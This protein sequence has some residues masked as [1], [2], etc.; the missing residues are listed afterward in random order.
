M[1]MAAPTPGNADDL[2][3]FVETDEFGDDWQS[4]GL[5]VE[6]DLLELQNAIM[7]AT[8]RAPVI[9]VTGGLRKM[10]FAPARWKTRK[11]GAIRVCYAYFPMNALVLL[12]M[13][14]GKA[15]QDDISSQEK[16]AIAGYLRQVGLHLAQRRK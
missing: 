13:R 9:Q 6:H 5:D 1:G 4:L 3:T 7:A 14:Y 2:L 11:R 15:T 16:H 8:E 12:V 10:R